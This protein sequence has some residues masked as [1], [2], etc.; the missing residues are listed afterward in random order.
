MLFIII[1]LDRRGKV[2]ITEKKMLAPQGN[3]GLE[4]ARRELQAINDCHPL[5][6]RETLK[7]HCLFSDFT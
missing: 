1:I 3:R 2:V 4:I 6:L 5:G 7:R